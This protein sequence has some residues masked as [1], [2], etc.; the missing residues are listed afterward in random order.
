MTHTSGCSRG[1]KALLDMCWKAKPLLLP[2]AACAH[3]TATYL[4]H[5]QDVRWSYGAWRCFLQLVVASFAPGWSWFVVGQPA[6]LP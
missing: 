4:G 5:L 3:G 2:S 6:L 1:L